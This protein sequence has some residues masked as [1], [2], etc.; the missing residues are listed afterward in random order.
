MSF[1]GC[2]GIELLA[3]SDDAIMFILTPGNDYFVL[4]CMALVLGQT[5]LIHKLM[6]LP[7]YSSNHSVYFRKFCFN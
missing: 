3:L 7:I 5:Q 2:F 1:G 6:F 4:L